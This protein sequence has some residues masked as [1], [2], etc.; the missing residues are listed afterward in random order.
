[1][2]QALTTTRIQRQAE[3]FQ[4][5][6]GFSIDS[7]KGLVRAEELSFVA[8]APRANHKGAVVILRKDSASRLVPEVMLSGE[9]LT[10]GF[11]YSLAVADLNSDG[12]CSGCPL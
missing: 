3:G 10:S 9:R 6:R 11:G 5:W 7:G 8:G 1:M 2:V 12:Y 4:C